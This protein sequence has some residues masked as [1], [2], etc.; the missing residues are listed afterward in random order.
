MNAFRVT[1]SSD[2]VNVETNRMQGMMNG[3][4]V[5]DSGALPATGT[6]ETVNN[7]AARAG[8][9]MPNERVIYSLGAR[10]SLATRAP[11]R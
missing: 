8:A 10:Q 6:A 7:A 4:A 1:S 9:P 5:N 3:A 11:V 2:I